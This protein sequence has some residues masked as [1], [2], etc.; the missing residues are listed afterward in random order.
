M[1]E[2]NKFMR[3]MHQRIASG[4]H[5]GT[6]AFN[7]LLAVD[8]DHANEI[9]GTRLDPSGKDHLVDGFLSAVFG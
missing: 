1:I 5:R 9:R 2:Y 6:A 7:T 4:E 3:L 8:P